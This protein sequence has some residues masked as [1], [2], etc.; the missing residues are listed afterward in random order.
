MNRV[1]LFFALAALPLGSCTDAEIFGRSAPGVNADRASFGGRVCTRDAVS[2]DLPLRLVIVADRADGPLF[3]SFDPAGER[4]SELSTFAQVALRNDATEMAV[5]GYASRSQRLAPMDGNFSQ[6]L[7]ELDAAIRSLA[8]SQSCAAIDAC[9]DYL[10]GLRAA[11]ALIEGDIAEARA[12]T[13]SLTQ[14]AV[15]LVVAGP[16]EPI[17]PSCR[18]EDDP[19]ACQSAREV[20]AVEDLVGFVRD[21]GALGVKVH[22][23]HFAADPDPAVN[24]QVG[25]TLQRMAFAGSG[26]YRRLDNVGGLT[27]SDLT[28]FQERSPLR[29]KSLLAYNLNAAISEQ[30][31]RIDSDSDGIADED[32]LAQGTDPLLRDTDGDGIGDLIENLVRF[33]PLMLDEPAACRGIDLDDDRELDGLTDCEEALLGTSSN[34]ADTDGDSI[35]D[36][37]EVYALANFLDSDAEEDVDADGTNNGDELRQHSDPRS[38]DL[39]AQL[40]FGYRYDLTD[41][42]VVRD[43]L[44]LEL[45]ELTGLDDVIPSRGTTAGVGLLEYTLATNSLR[46]RDQAD[47]EFGPAVMIPPEGG[48]IRLT[49]SSFLEEEGEDGRFI[50][51]TVDP[52][53]L[54]PRDVT[55]PLRII[56]QIR[57]CLSYVVRNVKLMDTLAIEGRPAGENRILLFF[58]EA[59]EERLQ[60]PGPIR[61]AEI[62]VIFTPPAAR[63]PADAVIPVMESEFVSP[64]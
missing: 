54:P 7:S 6:N 21:S 32:E 11:R 3:G 12:G 8:L 47:G 1:V 22:V 51:L 10:E 37:V 36:L 5:I 44:P 25:A 40:D 39:E 26:T 33:D 17:S 60:D 2:E 30:G 59:T 48:E 34:L 38:A 52:A 49:S 35:P 42:G 31:P 29:I 16:Q 50:E 55:E 14:Y 53:R 58:S 62:P 63:I 41:E 57:Q 56:F 19:Q 4:V 15:V 9:R 28:V 45:Q 20:A 64:R 46:W 18:G 61:I 43:L 13:R 27:V 24:D 23:L